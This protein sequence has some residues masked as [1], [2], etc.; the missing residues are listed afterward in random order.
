MSR[1]VEA[2]VYAGSYGSRLKI[3]EL[4]LR[5]CRGLLNGSK[6]RKRRAFRL[7][8]PT[9][10]QVFPPAVTL[11]QIPS[12]NT[13]RSLRLHLFHDSSRNAP[14]TSSQPQSNQKQQTPPTSSS[15]FPSFALSRLKSMTLSLPQVVLPAPNTNPRKNIQYLLLLT[16]S[17]KVSEFNPIYSCT[18]VASA[19]KYG[20]KRIRIGY[21]KE[22]VLPICAM[23]FRNSYD[24]YNYFDSV[25]C[26]ALLTSILLLLPTTP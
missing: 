8:T 26:Y 10:M 1:G 15:H 6:R 12:S 14:L 20:P 2:G 7:A 9:Q 24:R 19:H 23:I 11:L 17:L 4:Y 22:R 13:Y 25:V 3:L 16:E 5:L 18:L 21:K